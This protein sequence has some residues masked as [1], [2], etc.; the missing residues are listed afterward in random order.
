[1]NKIDN[2]LLERSCCVLSKG[3]DMAV[4]GTTCQH[5]RRR[6]RLCIMPYKRSRSACAGRTQKDDCARS[7]YPFKE[8]QLGTSRRSAGGCIS[9]RAIDTSAKA[10][11]VDRTASAA[12]EKKLRRSVQS[13]Y[14]LHQL[15]ISILLVEL[16]VSALPTPSPF[17]NPRESA[18]N[19]SR[20][21]ES[22]RGF[23]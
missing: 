18:P 2:G 16:A 21:P 13:L 8:L 17:S 19:F 11:H 15:I 5:R 12:S 9:V 1:M 22:A 20:T 6:S 14:V 4:H 23:H 7:Y 10:A 3:P